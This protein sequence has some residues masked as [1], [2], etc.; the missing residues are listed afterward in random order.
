[1]KG[2]QGAIVGKNALEKE[3]AC[4]VG[5]SWVQLDHS[6][7]TVWEQRAGGRQS[8]EKPRG[9]ILW[10]AARRGIAICMQCVDRLRAEVPQDLIC[11]LKTHTQVA[12]G[13]GR[14]EGQRGS[15]GGGRRGSKR[16]LQRWSLELGEKTAERGDRHLQGAV[17]M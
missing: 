6:K 8:W 5:L 15:V 1:M 10:A 4:R 9:L 17:S 14:E 16:L 7:V 13:V 3:S 12:Q 2:S 11:K